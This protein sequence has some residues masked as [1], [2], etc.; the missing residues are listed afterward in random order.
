MRKQEK[1]EEDVDEYN[2]GDDDEDNGQVDEGGM[3]WLM[4]D[5]RGRAAEGK[6]KVVL[7]GEGKRADGTLESPVVSA[8]TV[9]LWT[10]P[11]HCGLARQAARAMGMGWAGLPW[12]Q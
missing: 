7:V 4:K 9:D 8:V 1:E 5:G 2:N 6:G 10:G 11:A 12:T 3:P